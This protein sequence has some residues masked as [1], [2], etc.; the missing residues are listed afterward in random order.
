LGPCDYH[1]RG[2]QAI[3]DQP[4]QEGKGGFGCHS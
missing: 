1:E 3:R 2:R 4:A